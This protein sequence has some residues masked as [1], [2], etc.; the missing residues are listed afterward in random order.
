MADFNPK[1]KKVIIG[2]CAFGLLALVFAGAFVRSLS[3]HHD[4][5]ADNGSV[6][7]DIPDGHVTD[8]VGSKTDAYQL[9]G[10]YEDNIGKESPST[11]EVE[12]LWASLTEKKSDDRS[13]DFSGM[14]LFEAVAAVDGDGKLKKPK[15]EPKEEPKKDPEAAKPA[16]PKPAAPK[17]AANPSPKPRPKKKPVVKEE[18]VHVVGA[19]DEERLR[20][21]AGTWDDWDG[22]TTSPDTFS[23]DGESQMEV[24]STT[25]V[26]CMFTQA[27]TL[28]SG[29]RVMVRSLDPIVTS[30]VT[31]PRN[32]R[33]AAVVNIGQGR[34]FLT[35][36]GYQV[37]GQFYSV[38]LVAYD[39]DGGRGLYCPDTE[40]IGSK[41]ATTGLSTGGSALS[42]AMG[43]SKARAISSLITAVVSTGT[44][45]AQQE[46]SKV[47]VNVPS[48]YSFFLRNEE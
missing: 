30:G 44:N 9:S 16:P 33:L 17:A 25:P 18:P 34:L 37:N 26:R 35:V 23:W 7:I 41:A 3:R 4:P 19:A 39:S 40:N 27:E 2:A 22:P 14:D 36:T 6:L 1:K 43:S 29:Q 32:T 31:I 38:N 8:L 11:S 28:K 48:G 21:S 5:E 20:A 47:K 15:E 42:S 10:S 12:D 13:P 45:L 24:S 46:L